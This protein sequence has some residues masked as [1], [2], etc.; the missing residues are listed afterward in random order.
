MVEDV[1]KLPYERIFLW[2]LVSFTFI[3]VA[4]VLLGGY[5]KGLKTREFS[6]VDIDG[7]LTFNGFESK[8]YT[9]TFDNIGARN[10]PGPKTLGQVATGFAQG[11]FVESVSYVVTKVSDNNVANIRAFVGTQDETSFN[12]SPPDVS[13][14]PRLTA[15][16]SLS[17]GGGVV[18]TGGQFATENSIGIQSDS[19]D[20]LSGTIVVTVVVGAVPGAPPLP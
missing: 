16:D 3:T 20:A 12:G 8:T 6:D 5:Q 17:R 9:K 10:A 11:H 1:K 2:I 7:K 15:T 18:G 19:L 13:F 14:G 4:V